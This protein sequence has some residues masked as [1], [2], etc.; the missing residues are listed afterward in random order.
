MA[1][2]PLARGRMVRRISDEEDSDNDDDEDEQPEVPER[3]HVPQE[4][5]N[6]GTLRPQTESQNSLWKDDSQDVSMFTAPATAGDPPKESGVAPKRLQLFRSK[7]AN[8]FASRLQDEEQIFL[9]ELVEF[10]NAGL[11]TDELFGTA[12]ATAICQLMTD[13]DEL[14]MS[15]GIIYKV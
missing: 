2:L 12:E 4:Q 11:P 13:S 6:D 9:A 3:L 14:M 15:D 1:V 5:S 10:V 8:L 7:V